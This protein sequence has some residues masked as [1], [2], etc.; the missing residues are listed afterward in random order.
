MKKWLISGGILILILLG[1]SQIWQVDNAM[2][3]EGTVLQISE[4]SVLL[5]QKKE[6]SM[7][8]LVKT[9]EEWMEGDYDLI[10]VSNVE[11]VE[12]GM[13]LRVII[14]GTIAE[15]YPSQTQAKSYEILN[16]LQIPKEESD[17]MTM[18]P[19]NPYNQE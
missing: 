12:V 13:K 5:S 19:E 17:E 7:D 9:Y 4:A 8:D 10:S 3:I 16:Q 15:S 18:A 1:C 6:I 11:G 14:S 2:T